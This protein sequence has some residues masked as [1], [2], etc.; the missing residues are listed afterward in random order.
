MYRP[1]LLAKHR[2]N[3]LPPCK[4][5]LLRCWCG[6]IRREKYNT[7]RTF[8]EVSF[9]NT[10]QICSHADQKLRK[11]MSE[12]IFEMRTSFHRLRLWRM[13]FYW[14]YC[15]SG[16]SIF[17][18]GS[19]ACSQTLT[20]SR[21]G[22]LKIRTRMEKNTV[23]S[24]SLIADVSKDGPWDNQTI[25]G[26][27]TLSRVDSLQTKMKKMRQPRRRLMHPIVLRTNSVVERH[28]ASSW[29]PWAK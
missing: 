7:V 28:S 6:S 15:Q 21:S 18:S 26:T 23:H 19:Q 27:P 9:L 1:A 11:Q 13:Y 14:P 10:P 29:L 25:R 17:G 4:H 24:F 16:W 20:I 2:S 22:D 5:F 8:R 12:W 3:Q